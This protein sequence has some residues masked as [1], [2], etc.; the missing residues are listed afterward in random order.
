LNWKFCRTWSGQGHGDRGDGARKRQFLSKN[1]D[2]KE[3]VLIH[4][5]TII[6]LEAFISSKMLY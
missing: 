4:D 5:L 3:V 2:R 6:L 1:S